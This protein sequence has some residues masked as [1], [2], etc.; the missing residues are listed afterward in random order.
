MQHTGR[1]EAQS[2]GAGQQSK[3]P[4]CILEEFDM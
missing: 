3:N 1:H 4:P 2:H